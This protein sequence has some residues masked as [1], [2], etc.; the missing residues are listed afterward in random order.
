[1]LK[2]FTAVISAKNAS[3][4]PHMFMHL[5]FLITAVLTCSDLNTENSR[6]HVIGE[7]TGAFFCPLQIDI[8]D[9]Q[10]ICCPFFKTNLETNLG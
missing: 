1:M 5:R 4:C 10:E 9:F 7:S 8:S 6:F 3:D 2:Y